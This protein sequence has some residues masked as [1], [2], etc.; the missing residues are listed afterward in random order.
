MTLF[1]GD[2]ASDVDMS[3]WR[4]LTVD[5]SALYSYLGCEY[6]ASDIID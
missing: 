3:N 1:L 6:I 4:L 2:E 5:D